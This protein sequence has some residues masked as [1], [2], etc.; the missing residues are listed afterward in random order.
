MELDANFTDALYAMAAAQKKIQNYESALEYLDKVLELNPD[1]IHA[2]A[3]KKL[4]LNK[5]IN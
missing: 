1:F 5:Y 4:I 2:R 3:L